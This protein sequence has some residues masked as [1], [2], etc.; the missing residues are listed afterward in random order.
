MLNEDRIKDNIQ[1]AYKPILVFLFVS[2]IFITA[3]IIAKLEMFSYTDGL[4]YVFMAIT[5]VG[6]GDIVQEGVFHYDQL[7][8]KAGFAAF[9]L[10]WI[11]FGFISLGTVILSFLYDFSIND[12]H[13]KH[14]YKKN[15]PELVEDTDDFEDNNYTGGNNI[16]T[17]GDIES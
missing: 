2:Y 10:F 1:I 3:I 6:F 9:M 13:E 14:F 8:K 12:E 7:P 4:W 11:V 15:E 17:G 16:Y 5:T